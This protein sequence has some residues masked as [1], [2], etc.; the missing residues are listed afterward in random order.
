M[1]WSLRRVA[2]PFIQARL[3]M[4]SLYSDVTSSIDVLPPSRNS[5]RS[6]HF[7][8]YSSSFSRQN[9]KSLCVVVFFLLALRPTGAACAAPLHAAPSR[10]CL[11]SFPRG[12]SPSPAP[13]PSTLR[14]SPALPSSRMSLRIGENVIF[15]LRH[16]DLQRPC[17]I[18]VGDY[19]DGATE[20]LL[21]V[22]CTELLLPV[23]R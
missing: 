15:P 3:G 20:L 12:S 18:Y 13:A 8:I 23:V 21:P 2:P 19:Q 14:A 17:S 22:A 4:S 9:P 10:L 5:C 7:A 6:G 11:L 16:S 1:A